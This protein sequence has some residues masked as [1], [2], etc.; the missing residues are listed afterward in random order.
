VVPL[1]SALETQTSE[2]D[3]DQVDKTHEERKRG[4]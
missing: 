1:F 4:M 2:R 3:L